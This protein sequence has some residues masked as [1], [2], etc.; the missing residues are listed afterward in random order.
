MMN[1]DMIPLLSFVLVTTFTPGP[2]NIS[3]ASMGVLYGYRKTLPYLVGIT[4]GFC[5][6]MF[7]CACLTN[8]LLAAVP[9]AEKVLRLV[10]AGYIGW[11][12]IVMLKSNFSIPA[13]G[14]GSRALTMDALLQLCNPK[15]AVYG[16][17]LYSTFLAPISDRLDYLAFSA[18]LFAA[19][20]FMATSTWT[21]F[22][23]A[24]KHALRNPA[25]KTTI[26]ILLSFLP[27]VTAAALSDVL[28][29]A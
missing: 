7:V 18:V 17:T 29:G 22:G 11:L 21:L 14:T 28:G 5:V 13:S 10:G 6:V 4:L 12:A 3:S 27:M 8:T 25:T 19:T 16:L 9:K 24:I 2:N 20:S 23:A 1:I 26:N 15:V